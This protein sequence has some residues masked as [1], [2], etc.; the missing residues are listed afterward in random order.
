[1][2][3]GAA[4]LGSRPAGPILCDD[5]PGQRTSVVAVRVDSPEPGLRDRIATATGFDR[6]LMLWRYETATATVRFLDASL[7]TA[8]AKPNG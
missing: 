3:P 7:A 1:V 2:G 4:S 8:T 5:A 6:T